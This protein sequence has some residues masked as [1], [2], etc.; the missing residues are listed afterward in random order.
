[1][2]GEDLAAQFEF[3]LKI[4]EA[5]A[6]M[7]EAIIEL[8]DARTQLEGWEKR[9][10]AT[11]ETQEVRTLTR[12][13]VARLTAI[14]EEF[15]NTKSSSRMG[16]PPPNVPTRLQQKLAMLAAMNAAADAAPTRQSREVLDLLSQQVDEQLN[17]L[18][19][20]LTT[21]ISGFNDTMRRLDIPAVLLKS[22]KELPVT[23]SA[24]SG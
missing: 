19:G 20:V 2:S 8:R 18:S 14:E 10:P 11:G 5:I 1:V 22:A 21:E 4:R 6:R 15:V 9:L 7:N 24:E 12:D 13:L 23:V 17:K 3:G 16:Y